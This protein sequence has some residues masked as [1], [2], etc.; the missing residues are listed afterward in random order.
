MKA[1]RILL[2]WTALSSFLL[3]ATVGLALYQ[4]NDPFVF[5]FLLWFAACLVVVFTCRSPIRLLA[6]YASLGLLVLGLFEAYFAGWLPRRERVYVSRETGTRR[7]HRLHPVLG[8]AAKAST[9]VQEK[10]LLDDELVYHVTYTIDGDGLR[11]GPGAGKPDASSVLFLGGSFTF[12]HGVNDSETT[13][14]VFEERAEGRFRSFNFGFNGYGPHQMLA[15]LDNGYERKV[16]K[17][18]PPKF[19]IY[20]AIPD[21]VVRCAGRAAWDQAGPRYVLDAE[22]NLAY[23]GSF[24]GAALSNLI[25]LINKSH[26]LRRLLVALWKEDPADL[27]LFV[28][29]VQEATRI[30]QERYEGKFYVLAW[31]TTTR[32]DASYEEMLSKLRATSLAVVEIEHIVAD[33]QHD[34]E[35]YFIPGDPHSNA[36]AHARVAEFLSD[37]LQ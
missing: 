3:L 12:G 4:R 1:A 29:I 30:F 28:A 37:F 20:Q 22:G 27:D 21:H 36:F 15:I 13:A 2:G 26:V 24:Q 17:D 6:F 8:Y 33:Y 18:H 14:Y 23:G 5:V 10:K 16:V 35:K 9:R 11:I 31:D 25:A 19:A 7:L 34:R 32:G